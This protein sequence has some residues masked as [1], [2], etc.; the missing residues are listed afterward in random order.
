MER[1]I[2]S[3]KSVHPTDGVGYSHVARVGNTLYI[4]GQV[5]LDKQN[6]IVGVGDIESQVRQVYANLRAILEELGGSMGDIVKITTYLTS[7]EHLD[8]FRKVR[9]E[10]LQAPFPPNTLVFVAGLARPE[11]LVEI[12]AIAVLRR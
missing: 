6:R 1:E 2:L 5:P 11:Y 7:R 9:D 3:P 8:A 12:E 10:T 4:A